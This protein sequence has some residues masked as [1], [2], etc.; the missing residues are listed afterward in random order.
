MLRVLTGAVLS[1]AVQPALA[2]TAIDRVD[3]SRIERDNLP[4]PAKPAPDA[5]PPTAAPA[6]NQPV[7]GPAVD[8]GAIAID[9]LVG[10]SERDFSDIVE[11]YIGRALDPRDLA[12]L[13]EEIGARARGRGY[14]FATA[15]I[16]PQRLSAGILRIGYS[17]GTIEAIRLEGA[18]VSSVREALAPLIGQPARMDDVERR[19]LIAG[20]V[21]GVTILSSRYVREDGRGTLVVRLHENGVRLRAVYENDSTAPIGPE[22][23]R[24]DADLS[25]VIDDD[26]AVTLT[27]V[28]TPFEPD[29]LQYGRIGYTR[30]VS[31]DGTEVGVA[32]AASAT[33][34]GAYLDAL[35]ISGDSLSATLSLRHPLHRR[36]DA[37]LWIAG[38]LGLRDVSQYRAGVLRRS[39]RLFTVRVSVNGNARLGGGVLRGAVTLSQG[40]DALGATRMGYPLASRDDADGVFTTLLGSVDWVRAL[41][42]GFSLRLAAQ[43]QLASSPLLVAEE[44]GLGGAPFLRG[45]DYSER[46]GDQ[47]YMGLAELRYDWR[48]PLGLGR[49]AQ[50]YGFVDGGRVTNLSDGFGGGGLWSGGGGLRADV[51]SSTDVNVEVAL[52]LAGPRYETDNREPRL[53]LRLLRLF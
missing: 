24:I 11:R 47:G 40:L 19:L 45:Y 30:R 44:I 33:H 39:D 53:N 34:P 12:R 9:G 43:A 6:V 7:A 17:P 36:R 35:D 29:E 41:G 18:E 46:S 14:M 3:P 37:S 15:W 5:P 42:D 50:L 23:L 8:V 4:K 49:K 52:P 31:R 26:D 2:Q 10:L 22:Q 38:N 51:S 48:N 21:A 1:L 20:D 13:A 27:Y 32:L 28:V 16:A 25:G